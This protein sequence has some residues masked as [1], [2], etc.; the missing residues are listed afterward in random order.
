MYLFTYLQ[1]LIVR[2]VRDLGQYGKKKKHRTFM[3]NITTEHVRLKIIHYFYLHV[4]LLIILDKNHFKLD[5][6]VLL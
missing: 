1:F 4:V 2:N 3:E 5:L 6:I